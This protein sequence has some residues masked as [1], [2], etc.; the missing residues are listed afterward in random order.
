MTH[1]QSQ[2]ESVAFAVPPVAVGRRD[3]VCSLV[4][5]ALSMA[6]LGYA[7]SPIAKIGIVLAFHAAVLLIPAAACIMRYRQQRELTVA[8]LL[9]MTTAAAGPIGALGCA[10]FA[11]ALWSRQP[12]P[13][14]LRHW[15][16]YIS[17]IV[18]RWRIVHL[19]EELQSGRLPSDTNAAVPRFRPILRS[20]PV[21]EQ[22]RVLGVLGRRYHAQFRAVLREA[23]RHRN[24]FI[25]AQAAAVATRLDMNEKMRLWSASGPPAD[26][27]TVRPRESGDPEPAGFPLA[28]E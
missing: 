23:L 19:Y 12:A 25:R 8:M 13:E 3:A 26:V 20:A 21:E 11:L 2:T 14:R 10:F 1:A 5:F 4:T 18:A 6:V 28:R 15:Y 27:L 16:E 24:G 17:G 22:Q 7:M 9:L